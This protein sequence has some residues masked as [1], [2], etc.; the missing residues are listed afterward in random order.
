MPKQ[1]R[2]AS[3]HR[4]CPMQLVA[5]PSV[6]HLRIPTGLRPHVLPQVSRLAAARPNAVAIMAKT[7][8]SFSYA[9]HYRSI[10]TQVP[11]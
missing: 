7:G 11:L 9:Y 4:I 10:T 1:S 8:T 2:Y 6:R 5:Q 3:N